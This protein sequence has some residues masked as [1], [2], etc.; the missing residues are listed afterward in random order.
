MKDR[1]HENKKA[2]NNKD[3]YIDLPIIWIGLGGLCVLEK[4]QELREASEFLLLP[5]GYIRGG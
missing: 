4:K 2:K 3:V 1:W 5:C